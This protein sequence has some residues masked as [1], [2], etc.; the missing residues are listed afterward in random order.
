MNSLF[1]SKYSKWIC[2]FRSICMFFRFYYYSWC[3]SNVDSNQCYAVST[4]HVSNP[5]I[6]RELSKNC[7]HT[8]YIWYDWTMNIESVSCHGQ[9]NKKMWQC[10]GWSANGYVLYYYCRRAD[11]N[12]SY[13]RVWLH[14]ATLEYIKCSNFSNSDRYLL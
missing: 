5:S 13:R 1:Q 6:K 11:L 7:F 14:F 12:D 3:I 4:C 2:V 10:F 8:F 9:T